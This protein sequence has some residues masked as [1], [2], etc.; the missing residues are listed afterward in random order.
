VDEACLV[1]KLWHNDK[2]LVTGSRD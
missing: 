1:A 2:K